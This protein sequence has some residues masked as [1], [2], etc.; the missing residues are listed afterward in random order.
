MPGIVQHHT[1]FDVDLRAEPEPASPLPLSILPVIP[2][3][4]LQIAIPPGKLLQLPR[5]RRMGQLC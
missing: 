2:V 4:L 3:Q 1:L 5:P